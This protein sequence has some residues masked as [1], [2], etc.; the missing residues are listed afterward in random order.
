MSVSQEYEIQ[1]SN[2][3]RSLQR[4]EEII[5]KLQVDK[6]NYASEISNVRDLNSTVETKKEQI[7]RQL[8]SQEI[9]NDQLQ[10]AVS[11][12]KM[13]IDMLRTQINNEKAMIHSL[14]EMIGA[15]REKEFQTHSQSQERD[16]E[17]QLAKERAN[18]SDLKV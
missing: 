13:E 5:K 1:L 7:L 3:N 6:Q 16:A 9:E 15:S 4:N 18:M 10:A 12:M 17:L 14:E 2:M 11:D 8:T